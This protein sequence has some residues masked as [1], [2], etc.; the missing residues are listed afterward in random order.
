MTIR[1]KTIPNSETSGQEA[2]PNP[3]TPK[4]AKPNAPVRARAKKVIPTTPGTSE[5]TK[6]QEMDSPIANDNAIEKTDVTSTAV[7]ESTEASASVLDAEVPNE[8]PETPAIVPPKKKKSR[9]MKTK[10]K[11]QDKKEKAKKAKEKEKA[12]E[13]AK[14]D[15]AKAKE[16]EKKKKAKEKEKAK[17]AKKKKKSSKKK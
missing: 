4:T 6:A 14:K 10:E 2:K 8:Q 1:R 16:K 7:N 13:K 12:K 11:E 17:K 3:A 5:E 9:K 15:K